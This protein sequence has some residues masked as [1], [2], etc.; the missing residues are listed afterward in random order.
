LFADGT[1]GDGLNGVAGPVRGL[2][3]G[4]ASQFVA[5]VIGVVAC[6]AFAMPSFYLALKVIGATI[7]NRVPAAVEIAGLDIPEMGL[8]GYPEAGDASTRG[9][10]QQGILEP[11][12]AH[13][14]LRP[15][16]E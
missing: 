10:Q 3:Y 12:M 5:E 8:L 6:F 16:T 2:F 7:G 14:S 13:A 15:V 4:D 1:Y 9:A 11:S